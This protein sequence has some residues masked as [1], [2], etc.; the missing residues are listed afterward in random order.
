MDVFSGYSFDNHF[1]FFCGC[2]YIQI[3]SLWWIQFLTF[4]LSTIIVHLIKYIGTNY[5]WYSL[6][7]LKIPSISITC[8]LSI[9]KLSLSSLFL[10]KLSKSLSNCLFFPLKTY[11]HFLFSLILGL[12]ELT[13]KNVRWRLLAGSV[14]RAR[15][16]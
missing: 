1:N 9:P 16:S 8:Y 7:T 5:M 10:I 13:N 3:F 2:W 14:C 4:R 12:P 11:F 6:I 15:D